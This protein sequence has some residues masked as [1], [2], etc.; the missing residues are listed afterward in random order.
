MAEAQKSAAPALKHIVR[1]ANVD[2]PG[3]KD[4]VIALT[5]I[6]GIGVNLAHALCNV[7]KVPISI[8]AG[9]LSDKQITSLDSTV[10]DAKSSVPAWMLNHRKDYDTGS[11]KHHLTGTL[12]FT[13][14]T[15]IKRMRKIK[16]YKGVRHS[17]RLP[18]RGQ[19]TKSNFRRNKGKVAGLKKN[20]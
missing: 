16:C 18:V 4:V 3:G 12:S 10:K 9:A 15:D 14:E 17:K 19:R 1:I 6:K 11:D 13:V 7:A 20:K 2:I 8:K 5:K